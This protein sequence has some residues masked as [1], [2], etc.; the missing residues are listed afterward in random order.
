MNLEQV[1]WNRFLELALEILRQSV[2]DYYIVD[3]RLVSIEQNVVTIQLK[4]SLQQRFWTTNV[5]EILQFAGQE[6]FHDIL[7]IHYQL[8][9]ASHPQSPYSPG[10]TFSTPPSDLSTADLSEMT[11]L[12]EIPKVDSGLRTQYQFDNFIQGDGNT[13]ALAA[14]MAV[15]E[16]PGA[17]YNP[18]FIYGGPGLGK[19][20]LLNAIGNKVLQDNPEARVRIVTSETF[21]N[22]FIEYNRLNKMEEF[23]RN[24]RHLDVLLIDDIQTLK[25]KKATQEEFFNTFN[26]IYDNKKQIVLTSDRTPSQLD[27]ME[28][29]LVTRFSWGTITEVSPPDYETRIAILKSKVESL[30]FS[31]TDD[32][33][34]YLANQFHSNVRDLEGAIKDI[35]LIGHMRRLP[36]ISVEVAAQAIR[37]RQNEAPQTKV[38]AID[39]IQEEVGKFYGVSV[40]EIKGTKRVQ[41][42]VHARQVAMYLTRELT[43]N[44]LPKIGKEFGNKDHSTVMHAYNKIQALLQEDPNL[45]IEL[46]TIKNNIR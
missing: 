23:K 29:R 40:K 8:Q 35:E 39:R 34:A 43:D 14:S 30:P 4:N 6:V 21:L 46:T 27:N 28:D 11:S 16:E 42:I 26:A 22:E 45:E 15:A 17:R 2:Y 5:E 24:Y 31:F 12:S 36:E 37:A 13:F 32:T 44:S 20:H 33:L 41:H 10:N 19:T 7:T 1:F 9:Q 3:S 18:L 38:I 25:N